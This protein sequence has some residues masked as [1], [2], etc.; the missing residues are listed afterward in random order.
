MKMYP[1]SLCPFLPCIDPC[2]AFPDPWADR[3]RGYSRGSSCG[4]AVRIAN[5]LY[6]LTY[7][8]T[9]SGP[10][11]EHNSQE[12]QDSFLFKYLRGV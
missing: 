8:R 9:G 11:P 12:P 7:C 5:R 6:S 3:P 1:S 4:R 10:S 2:S